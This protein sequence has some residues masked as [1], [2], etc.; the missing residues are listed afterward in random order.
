MDWVPTFGGNMFGWVPTWVLFAVILGLG[1]VIVLLALALKD[2]L[3][4]EDRKRP[5]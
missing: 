2:K 1:G 5:P 3:E 4:E